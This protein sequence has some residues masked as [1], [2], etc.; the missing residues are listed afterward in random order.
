MLAN[1]YCW[2]ESERREASRMKVRPL[3]NQVKRD[4][5][6]KNWTGVLTRPVCGR[7]RLSHEA[8]NGHTRGLCDTVGCVGWVE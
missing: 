8:S 2:P 1:W 4:Q 6:G 7:L 3:I 5:R